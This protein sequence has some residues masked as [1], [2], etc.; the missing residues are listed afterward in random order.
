MKIFDTQLMRAWDAAT[1]AAE[2]VTS[3]ALMNRAA[4]AFTGRFRELFPDTTQPILV[5]CGSGNNGGDGLAVA[6]FL[7]QAA[8]E[9][10]VWLPPAGL[11]RSSDFEAQYKA[12]PKHGG[13]SCFEYPATPETSVLEVPRAAVVI[14]ALFGTGLS[15][16]L[17]DF[18]A[19]LV[20]RLNGLANTIVSIDL[21]S[22]LSADGVVSGPCIRAA[23]TITFERPKPAFF[24]AENESFVGDWSV[25]PIGLLPDFEQETPTPYHL[26]VAE[27]IQGL[28]RPR[29]RFAHKGDFGHALLVAGAYGKMGAAVLAARGALRAGAGLLTVHAPRCGYLVLQTAVPEA[30]YSADERARCLTS[31][32]DPGAF[33]AVGIGPGIGQSPETAAALAALLEKTAKPVVIDADALNLLSQH[34]DW[35]AQIPA[36]SILT[37]HPKEF[38][39]LFGACSDSPARIRTLLEKAQTHRVII[40]LK[41][42]CTAVGLPNGQVWFNTTGNPG[43]AT[44]GS[45]DVLTGVLTALLAQGYPPEDAAR[46]GVYLHGLAGDLAVEHLGMEALVAGDLPKGLGRAFARVQKKP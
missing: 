5:I 43:M 19:D 14:D 7:H 37:P 27:D 31:V 46:M 35:W 17:D 38:E 29:R 10:T 41:G 28:Y 11:R 45:G 33:D 40:V 25:V 2:P 44:G 18:W 22:G 13:V 15:R 12:L 20:E 4:L 32:P 21:P 42:A 23:F 16:P 24:F 30:M 26:T 8:Y 6:R 34:P 3:V 9:V 1:I 39:R 36:G